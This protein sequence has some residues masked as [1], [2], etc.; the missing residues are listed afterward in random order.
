MSEA[1]TRHHPRVRADDRRRRPTRHG[2]TARSPPPPAAKLRMPGGEAMSSAGRAAKQRAMPTDAHNG[3]LRA[4]APPHPARRLAAPASVPA[5]AQSVSRASHPVTPSPCVWCA[6][7]QSRDQG[8]RAG[9]RS[10]TAQRMSSI[11]Y[12]RKT[13]LGHQ[14]SSVQATGVRFARYS[15]VSMHALIS[16]SHL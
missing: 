6:V 7:G 3:T 1:R 16:R 13:R 10:G 11:T 12:L 15:L 8:A 5:Q 14:A 2:I 4:V 9:R